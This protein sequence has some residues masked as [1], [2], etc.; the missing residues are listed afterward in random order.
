MLIRSV[1]KITKVTNT[2]TRKASSATFTRS[3]TS[4]KITSEIR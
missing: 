3:R 4:A 1:T 2:R